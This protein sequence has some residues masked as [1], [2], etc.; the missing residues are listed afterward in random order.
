[1]EVEFKIHGQGSLH[2]DGMAL[3]LTKQRGTIGPVFGS[4]DNFDGLGLFI[5]TYKNQRPGVVFPY[6]MLMQGN[7][8]V[9]YDKDHDGKENEIAGCSARGIRTSSV[10]TKMRLTYFQEKSLKVDL[11]YKEN[12]W[13]ECFETGPLILPSVSYLGFSAETGE[14]SDNHDI[15]SVTTSNKYINKGYTEQGSTT[16]DS[17]KG[18]RKGRQFNQQREG[19]SWKWFFFKVILFFGVVVG[20]YVG[21]TMYRANQRGRF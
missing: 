13:T 7:G 3:W 19:G 10:A 17:N 2:G 1:I 9:K 14:L 18:G 21:W 8:S 15:I 20:G 16:T 11:Q 5:D 4:A 12:E 6:V